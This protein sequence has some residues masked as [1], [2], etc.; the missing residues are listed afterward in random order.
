VKVFF[1]SILFF[2]LLWGGCLNGQEIFLGGTEFI[3]A[4]EKSGSQR[5]IQTFYPYGE[6]E[7]TWEQRIEVHY[8][9]DLR[10]PRRVVMTVLERLRKMYPDLTYKFLPKPE[11]DRAGISYLVSTEGETEVRLEFILYVQQPDVTGLIAYRFTYRSRGPDARYAR[12]LF[13][14]KWDYYERAF[15]ET[16]WP[17]SLEDRSRVSAPGIFA[18]GASEFGESMDDVVPVESRSLTVRLPEGRTLE[19]DKGFLEKH[20]VTARIP[21]FY[22][23]VPKNTENLFIE[24]QKQGVPEVLKLSLAGPDMQ[25]VEN[26]RVFP[27]LLPNASGNAR[28]WESSGKLRRKIEEEYLN[29]WDDVRVFEPF[30]TIVGPS[31]AFVCLASFADKEGNRMFARFT[32][33]MPPVGERAILVFSQVDPRFASVKRLEDLESGGVMAGVAHSIRFLNPVRRIVDEPVVEPT[34]TIPPAESTETFQL[35]YDFDRKP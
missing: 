2:S 25:L 17:E 4:R 1:R 6:K 22:F 26:L 21:F 15:I 34:V 18:M 31:Q 10:Q 19:V 7:R 11:S 24:Y 13:R 14:G 9:P 33:I 8:Y 27:F 20:G 30:L 29:G 12:T 32:L 35:P 3:L 16:Q 5:E 23:S 28:L